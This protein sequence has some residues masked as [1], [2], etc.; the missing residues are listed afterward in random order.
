MRRAAPPAL[1]L[2][3]LARG[4]VVRE[5]L[6]ALAAVLRPVHVPRA[7]DRA[8]H[9]AERVEHHVDHRV[10]ERGVAR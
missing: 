4:E 2:D 8:E 9:A 3:A 10:V 1:D 6:D 5:G 7:E